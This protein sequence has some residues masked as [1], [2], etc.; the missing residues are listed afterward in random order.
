MMHFHLE[1][2]RGIDSFLK[3]RDIT[4]LQDEE[5]AISKKEAE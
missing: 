4:P 5:N 1:R 2:S 3:Q